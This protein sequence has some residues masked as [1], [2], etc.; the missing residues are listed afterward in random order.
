LE[1]FAPHPDMWI[2]LGIQASDPSL[3]C[4]KIVQMRML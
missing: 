2:R 4:G 3:P 1:H